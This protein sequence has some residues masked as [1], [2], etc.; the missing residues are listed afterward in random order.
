MLEFVDVWQ[1]DNTKSIKDFFFEILK[2]RTGS[3]KT[4]RDHSQCLIMKQIFI[5]NQNK[6]YV[7]KVMYAVKFPLSWP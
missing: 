6:K 4:D 5:Q 2:S 3:F 1:F 7:T